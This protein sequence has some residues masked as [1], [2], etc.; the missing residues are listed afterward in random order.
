LFSKK[1]NT[2]KSGIQLIVF[3]FIALAMQSCNPTRNIP[4]GQ[5]LLTRNRIVIK[6][7]DVDAQD[8]RS[9]IRQDPNRRLL[10][11]YRF[12]LHVYQ[13]ADRREESRFRNWLKNTIGEPPVL[14]DPLLSD[15]T[16]RQ[17]ELYLHNKGFFNAGIESDVRY[18]RKKATVTYTV[19]SGDAYSIRKID[20]NIPDRHLAGFVYADT[21]NSYISKGES[22]DVDILQNERRRITR[23]LKE[24]GFFNFSR[25]YIFF[26]VDSTLSSNQLD[27]EIAINN[28]GSRITGDVQDE[29]TNL[30]K[31]YKVQDIRIYPEYSRLLTDQHFP[32]TSFYAIE[33]NGLSTEYT[34]IH[35]GEMRI[36]PGAIARNILLEE[37]SFYN[38]NSVEQ[39]HSFLAALRNF[40][41]VNIQFREL[42]P[43]DSLKSDTMGYLGARVELT[44]SPSNAFTIEAEG[45]NTSGNLGIAGNLLYQN[46]NVFRGAEML[47]VRL[48]GA[49]EAA[50]ES[51][52][53]EVF[54]NLPFNTLE[55][56]TEVS[57][58]FP[59]LLL[60]FRIERLSRT[61]RPK[62]TILTGI[63]Y[64]QRPDYTRYILN[65]SYGFNWRQDNRRHHQLTPIE[66]SSIKIYNDSILQSRIPDANPLLLSRYRNHLISGP[67]YNYTY[68]SQQIDRMKD[69]I[70]FRSNLETSGNLMYLVADQL[71]G[72]RNESG[73]YTIFGIPFAQYIKADAD[74]RYYRIFDENNTLVFRIMGGIGVPYGN[75]DVMPFIKSYYGGGANSIRAWSIYNLGPGGY[76]EA[77]ALRFDK[78][79]DIKLEANIEYRFPLY[80]YWKAAL[81]ADAGNVW[82]LQ[83]N[84]QFPLG[85]F[86]P[87]RFYKEIAVGVGTGLRVDFNFFIIRLDAAFPLRNPA[88]A[89]GERW[90]TVLPGLSKWNFNLGIGY[91]F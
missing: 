85:N 76:P 42:T 73:N 79:G 52:D 8:L 12:H 69:F 24:E 91:P 53:Q 31:R 63:N 21:I 32:D 3:V 75:I 64:R 30:H 46:R 41:F 58:D 18:R 82:F 54:Q 9:F 86:A 38:I 56:G 7:N 16:K 61:A 43:A 67:G 59:E 37:G 60:P 55:M 22:Y 48:K 40:R 77:D 49:L 1:G 13:F 83:K 5:Y 80:R 26:R 72:S 34:F 11:V 78:Y 4:E 57:I 39:T 20:Y 89:E 66:V 36:R 10:G 47:N 15:Q 17:F 6:D 62:T 90:M 87:E 29:R 2:V 65:V 51:S 33:N 35:R 25:D 28:P 44:R 84:E 14:Y 19:K 70:Y 23:H 81:F 45:L 68:S 71:H 50:G 74:L 27:I 88:L